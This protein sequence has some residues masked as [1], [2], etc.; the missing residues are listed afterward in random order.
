MSESGKSA[1]GI[2]GE[3]K[4]ELRASAEDFEGMIE[5]CSLD[6]KIEH[7]SL[8]LNIMSDHV[9]ILQSSPGEAVVTYG[10]FSEGYFG[11]LSLNVETTVE[12]VS[13]GHGNEMEYESGC[14]A[15]INVEDVLEYLDY[16][17]SGGTISLNF[18]GDGESRLCSMLRAEGSLEA[19][20]NLP[21]SSSDLT[22]VPHWIP[23][24]YNDDEVLC[25]SSGEPAPCAIDTEVG[26]V[27]TI[28]DVVDS[29]RD[30]DFYPIVVEDEEFRIDVGSTH[31]SGVRGRLGAAK[32]G[33]PDVENFYLNGFK[34]I[35]SVLDG[36]VQLQLVPGNGLLSVVKYGDN[37][38]VRHMNGSTNV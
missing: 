27:E 23:S 8:Y 16:S 17:S 9:E 10:S 32:E 37:N 22:D 7:S 24:R 18:S 29:D 5:R 12:E 20:V 33:S 30:Q 38:I 34:E 14:E 25:S 26:S 15:I 1:A 36:Q 13:D 6:G 4:A 35:F 3:I 31:S 21:G 2:D 19:W 11:S 28:I